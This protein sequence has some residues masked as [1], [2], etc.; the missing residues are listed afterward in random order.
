[1]LSARLRETSSICSAQ[2]LTQAET[3]SLHPPTLAV[4]D[5]AWVGERGR[6]KPSV[7]RDAL[8]IAPGFARQGHTS[9]RQAEQS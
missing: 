1:M 5:L 2:D 8:N 6:R 9:E 3:Y 4:L 7:P